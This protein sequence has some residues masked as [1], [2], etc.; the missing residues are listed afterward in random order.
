MIGVKKKKISKS[1]MQNLYN[2]WM[3]DI[4][5]NF[6]TDLEDREKEHLEADQL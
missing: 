4:T 1:I 6:M 2:I 3:I 5:L